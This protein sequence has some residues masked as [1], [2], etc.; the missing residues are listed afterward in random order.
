[1]SAGRNNDDVHPITGWLREG[2]PGGN[3]CPLSCARPGTRRRARRRTSCD[4][5]ADLERALA[6]AVVTGL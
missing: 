6:A 4:L 3:V 2:P 1:M 5:H